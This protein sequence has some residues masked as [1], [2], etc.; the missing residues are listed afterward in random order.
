MRA[1]IFYK[2]IVEDNVIRLVQ[3]V[4]DPFLK[5]EILAGR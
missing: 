4:S 2:V 1:N 5:G 3:M